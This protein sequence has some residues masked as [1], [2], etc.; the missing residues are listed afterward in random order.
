M[1]PTPCKGF[2]THIYAHTHTQTHRIHH[3]N[4]KIYTRGDIISGKL[5]IPDLGS[6]MSK[7]RSLKSL[8]SSPA[9]SGILSSITKFLII[10]YF[11]DS[12]CRYH[13]KGSDKS[14]QPE[15]TW[16][17][18]GRRQDLSH[19][20]R[21]SVKELM[22]SWE[23]M[24]GDQSWK[25]HRPSISGDMIWW[26]GWMV[27]QKN[28]WSQAALNTFRFFVVICCRLACSSWYNH[29]PG[30]LLSSISSAPLVAWIQ[31]GSR[32]PLTLMYAGLLGTGSMIFRTRHVGDEFSL[33]QWFN[34]RGG[35]SV[36]IDSQSLLIILGGLVPMCCAGQWLL[37]SPQQRR[38][39]CMRSS[40]FW[41]VPIGNSNWIL[42]DG[43][44][45]Q[46]LEFSLVTL[47][48]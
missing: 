28:E 14:P 39:P 32:S 5:R 44:L 8:V 37:R 13:K 7:I 29:L 9:S 42:Y 27:C 18:Q 19:G 20:G 24:V 6:L 10:W 30:Y 41:S 26:M 2:G 46:S 16:L 21:P 33:S 23:M 4:K 17:P 22:V 36:S 40:C 12:L 11:V 48:S 25:P 34:W 35:F 45:V 1:L 47:G 3:Q 43:Q 38:R 15:S 31:E